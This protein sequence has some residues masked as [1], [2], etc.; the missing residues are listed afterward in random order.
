MLRDPGLHRA[1]EVKAGDHQQARA[2]NEQ[3]PPPTKA[4]VQCH[5]QISRLC[6]TRPY[7]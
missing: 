5:G 7:L 2:D 4:N 1:I 6:F 3:T